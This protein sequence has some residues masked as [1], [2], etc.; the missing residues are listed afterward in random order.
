[1]LAPIVIAAAGL[2]GSLPLSTATA[3]AIVALHG[4]P[5]AVAIDGAPLYVALGYGCSRRQ[6][7]ERWPV[8]RGGPYC[9]TVYWTDPATGQLG[10]FFTSSPAYVEA[11]GV[12]IG[13]PTVVA[14]RLL[15]R[16]A[17]GG[18]S[19]GIHFGTLTIWFGGG[20]LWAVPSSE[21]RVIGGHVASFFLFD[22]HELGIFDC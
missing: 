19:D 17:Q 7:G 14:E 15:H 16:H 18:C 3:P 22:E 10:D 8:G 6:S 4:R 12:R 2:I 1:M 5:D 20:M 21:L 9:Q 13:M 11:H